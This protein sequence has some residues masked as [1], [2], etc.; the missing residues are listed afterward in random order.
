MKKRSIILAAGIL[1]LGGVFVGYGGGTA[2]PDSAAARAVLREYIDERMEGGVYFLR[3]T[4]APKAF[5]PGGEAY[6]EMYE[7]WRYFNTN[8]YLNDADFGGEYRWT[9][10]LAKESPDGAWDVKEFGMP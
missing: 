2:D 7:D 5:C 1:L 9:A 3:M 10:V 4:E 8:F 6:D